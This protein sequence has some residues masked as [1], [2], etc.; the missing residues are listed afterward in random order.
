M[1]W[2]QAKLDKLLDSLSEW[3]EQR[4]TRRDFRT[5]LRCCVA[6]TPD[7]SL[8]HEEAIVRMEQVEKR[9]TDVSKRIAR[10]EDSFCEMGHL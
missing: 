10:I 4:M 9:L 3:P 5:L 6:G 2:D 7:A 8:R 1:V